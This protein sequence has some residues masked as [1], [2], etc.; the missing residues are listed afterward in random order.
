MLSV[1]LETS[2]PKK[3]Q[4]RISLRDRTLTN[5]NYSFSRVR[6]PTLWNWKVFIEQKKSSEK[7]FLFVA[8]AYLRNLCLYEKRELLLDWKVIVE[9]KPKGKH[10]LVSSPFGWKGLIRYEAFSRVFFS[11][12]VALLHALENSLIALL[13]LFAAA[14]FTPTEM[15]SSPH[16]YCCSF[17]NR[18]DDA[19]IRS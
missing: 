19:G 13:K 17:G 5:R 10:I 2:L 18:K 16:R 6:K 11:R 15:R 14:F 9:Q 1:F 12:R 8:T 4:M 3:L 7:F